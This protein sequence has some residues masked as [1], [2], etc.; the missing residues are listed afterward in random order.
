LVQ[1]AI[2]EYGSTPAAIEFERALLDQIESERR[3]K[4][5]DADRDKLLEIERQ[6]PTA[7]PSKLRQLALQAQKIAA[8]YPADD[9]VAS[10]A[11]RIRQRVASQLAAAPP[12]KPIP[13]RQIATGAVAVVVVVAGII[14]VPRLFRVTTVPVEI[15]T[16]PPGAS[17][18]IGD[19]SCLTPNCRLDL[20]PG[21]YQI[22][23]RLDGYK[24]AEQSLTVDSTK[25]IA[26]INLMMQPVLQPSPAGATSTATGTLVVKTGVPDALVSVDSVP[27]GRT[28]GQGVF[29][30]QLE[31]KSHQVRVEKPG[32]QTPH[33]LQVDVTST[34]IGLALFKLERATTEAKSGNA[35]SSKVA[36]NPD[37]KKN[38]GSQC[39]A[40]TERMQ[41]GETLTEDERAFLK[42]KCH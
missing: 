17:V 19:R 6:V 12:P 18:R 23:A 2:R 1:Q 27:R 9:E 10:I 20:K 3:Q 22:E 31:A 41:L 24:P 37:G 29:S 16:G 34:K 7:K 25:Q 5:R 21:Q 14:V 38:S 8:P 28:D 32:Y 33:E 39:Q 11:V 42:D 35:G 4:A 26:P 40:L 15:R 13:V 36:A 30:V